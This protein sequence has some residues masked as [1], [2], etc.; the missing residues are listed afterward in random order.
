VLGFAGGALGFAG[1]A[2]AFAGAG[3][4]FNPSFAAGPL[5]GMMIFLPERS[6]ALGPKWF[7]L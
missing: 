2:L 1:G 5:P 3:C 4:D 6:S 7:A